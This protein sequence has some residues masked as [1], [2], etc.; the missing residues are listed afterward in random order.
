MRAP[1]LQPAAPSSSGSGSARSKV[2]A[3]HPQRE[4]EAV[5]G[6]AC[7]PA[8]RRLR[9]QRDDAAPA[10]AAVRSTSNTIAP[11]NSGFARELARQQSVPS[12]TVRSPASSARDLLGQRQQPRQDRS[13]P[14]CAAR[15]D[16]P[17]AATS[18]SP[19]TAS[20]A[21]SAASSAPPRRGRAPASRSMCSSSARRCVTSCRS[22]SCSARRLVPAG[23]GSGATETVGLHVAESARLG[24]MRQEARILAGELV[25]CA[26]L[27]AAAGC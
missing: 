27:V 1:A 5:R 11:Q 24:P 7:R 17:I 15:P 18:Y 8:P 23:A 2:S 16:A 14:R 6:R 12:S 26:A 13:A 3:E 4:A 21:S 19:A 9:W 10:P 22:R 20:S 25:P